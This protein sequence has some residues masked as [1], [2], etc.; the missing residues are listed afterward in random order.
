MIKV[1][2]PSAFRRESEGGGN[3]SAEDEE[4]QAKQLAAIKC[5]GGAILAGGKVMD[6]K[7][8][9]L[10]GNQWHIDRNCLK[11]VLSAKADDGPSTTVCA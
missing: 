9:K 2:L 7:I 10:G 4:H 5:G 6:M 11:I 3:N 8:S 1:R